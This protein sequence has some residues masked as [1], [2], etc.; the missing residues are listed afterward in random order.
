MMFDISP[1]F[2]TEL[3]TSYGNRYDVTA[4]SGDIPLIESDKTISFAGVNKG[5]ILGEEDVLSAVR[6]DDIS[7]TFRYGA[8][9]R[10]TPF[11]VLM[12]RA[13]YHKTYPVV[14]DAHSIVEPGDTFEASMTFAVGGYPMASDMLPDN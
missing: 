10:A 2:G 7:R 8:T 1:V 4:I 14:Y 9:D 13:T 3:I 5:G 6:V 11:L 12:N